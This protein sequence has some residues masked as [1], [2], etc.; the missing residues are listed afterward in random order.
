MKD[1]ETI[2]QE[3]PQ[4]KTFKLTPAILKNI[5]TIFEQVQQMQ[6][7]SQEQAKLILD[8]FAQGIGISDDES[9]TLSEDNTSLIILKKENQ[10]LPPA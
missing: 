3:T 5:N 10:V 1:T 8:S 7:R 2:T 9:W 4:T 6:M